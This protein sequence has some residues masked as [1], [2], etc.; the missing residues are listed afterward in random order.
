M[1]YPRF[2]ELPK[3]K[4]LDAKQ[5]IYTGKQITCAFSGEDIVVYQAY[6]EQIANYAVQNQTFKGCPQY[7]MSRMTWIKSNFL[8]MHSANWATRDPNQARILALFVNKNDFEH[9]ILKHGVLTSNPF[10]SEYFD[11]NWT[12][13]SSE[14]EWRQEIART[15]DSS[16]RIRVQWDPYHQPSGE[17]MN[18]TR[19]IQIGLKGKY[20]ESLLNCVSK[21]EDITSYVKDQNA[22]RLAGEDVS[23]PVETV[24][25]IQDEQIARKLSAQTEQKEM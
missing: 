22:L 2:L 23:I 3:V 24:Y 17:K 19:A 7:R 21:F 9:E 20:L 11:P 13:Y 1:S 5:T 18:F 10:S 8:W 15:K 16:D 6:N 4:W 25:T 14:E 12:Y